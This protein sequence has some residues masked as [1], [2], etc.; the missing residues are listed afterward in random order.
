MIKSFLV[1]TAYA[2]GQ[3]QGRIIER[4]FRIGDCI[5]KEKL[6]SGVPP[7]YLPSLDIESEI[8][9]LSDNRGN[10]EDNLLAQKMREMGLERYWVT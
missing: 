9:L 8:N 6:V 10:I 7:K 4:P 1:I 2:N 3:R 5:A